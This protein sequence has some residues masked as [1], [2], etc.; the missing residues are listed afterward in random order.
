MST[1]SLAHDTIRESKL[2]YQHCYQKKNMQHVTDTKEHM[3]LL[4]DHN[5]LYAPK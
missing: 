5:K 2:L 1:F 3:M 4:S